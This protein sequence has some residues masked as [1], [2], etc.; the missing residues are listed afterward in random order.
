MCPTRALATALLLASTA[1][2]TEPTVWPQWRGPTRDGI[3]SGSAWPD[4][5]E[6]DAMKQLWR[7]EKL[8]P[9]YS[10]PIVAAD[11]VFTTQT[12][13]KKIEVVTAYDRKVR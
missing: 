9:S 1:S 2:A 5:L 6:G 8:G 10:G 4:K 13:D 3:V 11:R 12:V 7:V